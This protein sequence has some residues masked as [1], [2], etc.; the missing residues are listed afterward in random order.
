M[1]V[2]SEITKLGKLKNT[3]ICSLNIVTNRQKIDTKR[4]KI[5]ANAKDIDTKSKKIATNR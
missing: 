4:Q 5:Y 1:G 3:P 2:E